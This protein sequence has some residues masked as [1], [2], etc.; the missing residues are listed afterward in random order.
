MSDM[1][2]FSVLGIAVL[3]III[4]IIFDLTFNDPIHKADRES[5]TTRPSRPCVH[6]AQDR[7]PA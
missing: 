2:L 4:A 3:G 5:Q 7:T 1:Q 6:L